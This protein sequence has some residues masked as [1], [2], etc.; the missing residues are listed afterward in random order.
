ML[1]KNYPL[2]TI[3]IKDLPLAIRTK[4]ANIVEYIKNIEEYRSNNLFKTSLDLFPDY[5]FLFIH[6]NSSVPAGLYFKT[7]DSWIG[8]SNYSFI[9]QT[10]ID[11]PEGTRVTYGYQTYELKLEG[12]NK[13]WTNQV[14]FTPVLFFDFFETNDANIQLRNKG[15]K[16]SDIE[17]ILLDFK[18]ETKE[19]VPFVVADKFTSIKTNKTYLSG[20]CLTYSALFKNIGRLY[21]NDEAIAENSK[22]ALLSINDEF[23][24]IRIGLCYDK[25]N[26]LYFYNKENVTDLNFTLSSHL[27]YQ[28]SLRF[29]ENKL[30]ILVNNNELENKFD[31]DISDK[32]LFFGLCS[33]MSYGRY[34]NA[35]C[36][37]S[38]PQVFDIALSPKENLWL[39]ENPRTWNFLNSKSYIN[40]TLNEQL[41][42]KKNI[43]QLDKVES[44]DSDFKKL[45]E[46]KFKEQTKKMNDWS[47]ETNNQL[48]ELINNKLAIITDCDK[49]IKKQQDLIN[50]LNTKINNLEEKMFN[51]EQKLIGFTN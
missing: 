47:S 2:D 12:N 38:E 44:H 42:L 36:L 22:A 34:S 35:A 50:Q 25:Q 19:I 6:S 13:I 15:F 10:T 16:T 24:N 51:L 33:D 17:L 37:V 28:L 23:Q 40:L 43:N 20:K 39:M 3:A 5:K 45:I 31:I 27:P 48:Q 1:D 49:A 8:Y 30:T 7:P 32:K 29:F 9:P 21:S 41:K 18:K 4:G 46:D 26:K 14:N 11:I